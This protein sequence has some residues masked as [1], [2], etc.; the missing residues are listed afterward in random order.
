LRGPEARFSGLRQRSDPERLAT[1]DLLA[2]E[3]LVPIERQADRVEA[4]FRLA[5]RSGVVIATVG[6][7]SILKPS[8][9][10]WVVSDPLGL[11]V[12]R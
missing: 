7:K 8:A 11:S 6:R 10:A 3:I 9:L 4:R 2:V 5:G 12:P 1:G